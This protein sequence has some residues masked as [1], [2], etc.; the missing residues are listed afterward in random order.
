MSVSVSL[1][2]NLALGIYI[3]FG[4]H[5][6]HTSPLGRGCF[7]QSLSSFLTS[8][9]VTCTW[10]LDY[11]ALLDL[12]NYWS[13]YWR[14]CNVKGVSMETWGVSLSWKAWQRVL[15]GRTGCQN[16]CSWC[17]VLVFLFRK[18][19]WIKRWIGGEFSGRTKFHVGA[20]P[21]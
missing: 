9:L 20:L 15:R 17:L 6:L 21:L 8:F 7:M 1:M 11:R 16:N 14:K 12:L 19:G 13:D 3:L 18:L 10:C 4:K 5:P 2:L